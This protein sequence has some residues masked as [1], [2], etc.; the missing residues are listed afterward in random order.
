MKKLIKQI[1]DVVGVLPFF[2]FSFKDN[3]SLFKGRKFVRLLQ[4]IGVLEETLVALEDSEVTVEEFKGIVRKMLEVD[5]V[6][7]ELK[8]LDV[9]EVEAYVVA[10]REVLDEIKVEE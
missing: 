4:G 8:K 2:A 5:A 1:K 6:K 3:L 9:S 7:R 10:F